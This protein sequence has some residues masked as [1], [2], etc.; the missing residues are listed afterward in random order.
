MP[1][2]VHSTNVLRDGIRKSRTKTI[3]K[4]NGYQ[5]LSPLRDHY[6][7]FESFYTKRYPHSPDTKFANHELITSAA[8][9][10]RDTVLGIL[11]TVAREFIT[12]YI[13]EIETLLN[14][15]KSENSK[16]QKLQSSKL[17]NSINEYILKVAVRIDPNN[18]KAS[19]TL[20]EVLQT[21]AQKYV[22]DLNEAFGN[23]SE[24]FD[25]TKDTCTNSPRPEMIGAESYR[26][27][28]ESDL[29]KIPDAQILDSTCAWSTIEPRKPLSQ[30]MSPWSRI[31][32]KRRYSQ[33]TGMNY[34]DPADSGQVWNVPGNK[35]KRQRLNI[36]ATKTSIPTAGTCS[37]QDTSIIS[38]DEDSN[39]Q[40]TICTHIN[41]NGTI[42]NVLDKTKTYS[43][44][45]QE[46]NIDKSQHM[47]RMPG[48][49]HCN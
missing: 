35:L 39:P 17:I 47:L 19:A 36:Q 46:V 10:D 26:E 31:S 7:R 23:T 43:K 28:S 16:N 13:P 34:P 9:A 25:Y 5:L 11:D 21:R 42:L 40:N 41:D 8:S 38:Y 1:N 18:E 4:E 14:S 32:R 6:S 45:L 49:F 27:A 3:S 30:L 20:K 29:D 15:A 44:G 48:A 37:Q 24:T 12:Y 33:T 2:I 22:D